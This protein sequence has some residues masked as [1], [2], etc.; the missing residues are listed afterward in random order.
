MIRSSLI[1]WLNFERIFERTN[2]I[3]WWIGGRVRE[4]KRNLGWLQGLW[5]V[6][7][8]ACWKN[9]FAITKP[10]TR[11]SDWGGGWRIHIW[12]VLDSLR[13]QLDIQRRWWVD[14]LINKAGLKETRLTRDIKLGVIC[15]CVVSSLGI[16]SNYPRKLS[17]KR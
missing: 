1:L 14:S 8:A 2:R 7:W 13:C 9:R 16:G 11:I 12:T 5:L 17:V 3:L 4:K 6:V 10:T 15:M